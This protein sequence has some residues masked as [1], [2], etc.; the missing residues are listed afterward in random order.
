MV[1]FFNTDMKIGYGYPAAPV[2]VVLAALCIMAWLPGRAFTASSTGSMDSA[3]AESSTPAAASREYIYPDASLTGIARNLPGDWAEFGR[4]TFCRENVP[5]LAGIAASTAL[6]IAVDGELYE[7]TMELGDRMGVAQV[8]RKSTIVRMYMPVIKRDV[9]LLAVPNSLG[10]AM[11][12]I[13]DGWLQMAITG[14]F[15]GYGLALENNR[16]VK[17]A[18]ELVE[19]MTLNGITVLAI[20]MS[21]GRENPIN[22]ETPSGKWRFFPDPVTY[23]KN[24]TKYDAFP[25]GHL[26]SVMGTVTVISDNYPEYRWIRPVGYGLMVPLA[27]Q[28]VNGGVHWYSDY[29][30]ALYMGYTFAK[31][32]GGRRRIVRAGGTALLP[33]VNPVM[34][35]GGGGLELRWAI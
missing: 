29:P 34:L 20:K 7:R 27:F 5:V 24:V 31:I 13:G 23:L 1:I 2:C 26:A 16:A 32:A 21:T 4:R 17:T 8:E 19:T 12:F 30:L 11:Y 15:L 25:S 3:P 6:L 10:T 9:G 35:E 18:V 14:G 33:Q 22:R 28:M